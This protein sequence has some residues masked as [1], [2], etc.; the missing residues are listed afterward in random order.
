MRTTYPSREGRSTTLNDVWEGKLKDFV[1]VCVCV[2]ILW[3]ESDQDLSPELEELYVYVSVWSS[4][5]NTLLE[6]IL[7]TS[8]D[9]KR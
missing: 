7:T 9:Q 3:L 1:C 2:F 4:I 6:Q 8:H 5:F